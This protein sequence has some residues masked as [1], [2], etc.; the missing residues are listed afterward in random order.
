MRPAAAPRGGRR[1]SLA[2][3]AQIGLPVSVTLGSGDTALGVVRYVGAT[4][5]ADRT[6]VGV[7]L[8]SPMGTPNLRVGVR[9]LCE[10]YWGGGGG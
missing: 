1:G 4:A 10:S 9:S 3:A 5:F 7:E 2:L 8:D 6:W